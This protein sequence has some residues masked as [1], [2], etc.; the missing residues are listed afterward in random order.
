M[1][2][3]MRYVVLVKVPDDDNRLRAVEYSRGVSLFYSLK[4]AQRF[5]KDTFPDDAETMIAMTLDPKLRASGSRARK[6]KSRPELSR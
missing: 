4:S 3:L 1:V 6:R 5:I 2:D